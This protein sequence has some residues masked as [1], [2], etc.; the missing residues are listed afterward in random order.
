VPGSPEVRVALAKTH[1]AWAVEM[2]RRG[3]V[4]DAQTTLRRAIADDPGSREARALLVDS[5][6]ALGDVALSEREV[7]ALLAA[8]PADRAALRMLAA[9]EV[10]GGRLDDA[11]ITLRRLTAAAPDDWVGWQFL[12]AVLTDKGDLD[13]GEVAAKAARK[14]APDEPGALAALLHVLVKRG[15]FDAAE[16]EIAAATA[17]QPGEARHP[18]FLAML[19]EQQGRHE[20]A[21]AAASA[22]LDLRPALPQALQLA[23]QAISAGLGDPQRAAAFA[24]E[25]AAKA[26]DDPMTTFVLASLESDLG[27]R[28]EALTLLAPL[29]DADMPLPA[30]LTLRA[31]LVLE[32]RDFAAA[33]TVLTQGLEKYAD[34]ID[35]HYLLAQAWLGD[36]AHSKDGE[37]QDPARA[38][39]VAELRAVLK[40]ARFH[41]AAANNLAW[42]LSRDDATRAEALELAEANVKAYPAYAPY[43]DTLG[44][45]LLRLGR[46]DQAAAAF[47]RALGA[48]ETE[49][50]ALA[51]RA[52]SKP[53]PVEAAKVEALTKRLER[54]KS[55][56]QARFDEALKASSGR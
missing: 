29:C 55:E 52:A 54:T 51:K 5:L 18:L 8:D 20:E 32:T 41:P 26:K 37:P 45:V 9:L 27:R 30:A 40:V 39:A 33:R 6:R 16:R 15:D 53:S 10:Q 44:T 24:R 42:L 36:P 21:A 19:R 22:A 14:A 31:V 46:A 38:F 4:V 7:R 50:A 49:R 25:R 11:A 23:I 1:H 17:R 47:R 28:D 43:L 12:S 3:R 35:L 56:T 2:L 34:A 13:G 48:C